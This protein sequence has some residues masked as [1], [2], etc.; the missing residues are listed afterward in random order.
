MSSL[1]SQ[2]LAARSMEQRSSFEGTGLADPAS[3]PHGT[4]GTALYT[5]LRRVCRTGLARSVAW[6]VIGSGFSQGGSFLSSVILARVL[7]REFFGEF[8]LIQNTVA[9]VASMASL[10][11]GLAATKYVSEYRANQPEKIGKLLGF[12]S[13]LVL[14]AALCFSIALGVF[15]PKLA[16]ESNHSGITTGLRLSTPYVFFVTLTGYQ[17]G[18][19]A[20]FEAFRIIAQVGIICGLASPILSWWGAARFGIQ[21]AVVSQCAAAFLL[22][23]VYEIAV[24]WKCR[25][26]GIKMEFRGVWGER[27]ILTRVSIPAAAC[28]TV[29]SLAIWGSN[30]LLVKASGYRELALFTAI[31]N[32]RS[33]VMFLPGLIF[34][35]AAP[36]L[37]YLFAAGD[38]P[39]YRRTFWGAAGVNTAM[40]VVGAFLAFLLGHQFLRLFGREFV[41]SNWLLRLFL[42]SVVVEIAVNNLSQTVFAST[43]YWWNLA[44]MCLWTAAL[45]STSAVAT[46]RFGAAGLAVANLAAWLVAAGFH[47]N[48]ARKQTRIKGIYD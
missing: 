38:L 25:T 37:N 7:G 24:R 48:E 21:G 15:A 36:R 11:L 30:T 13:V 29:C 10:G 27:S 28:G 18:V 6:S 2:E 20:G 1:A 4:D 5:S 43:R 26:C 42:I 31:G 34:R 41:G 44:V 19:L 22:W 8:A 39:A 12:S 35:V 33:A 46:P 32:L 16:V 17:L 40:A 14:L 3:L 9:A 47:M 45:L 23:F